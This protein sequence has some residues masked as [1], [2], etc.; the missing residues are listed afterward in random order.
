MFTCYYC[1]NISLKEIEVLHLG[2]FMYN[3]LLKKN[4]TKIEYVYSEQLLAC[5]IYSTDTKKLQ[6]T[7]CMC[8]V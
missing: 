7:F 5:C 2:D 3:N 6:N 8:T 4:T 1:E